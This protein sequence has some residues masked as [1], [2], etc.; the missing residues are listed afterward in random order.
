MKSYAEINDKIRSGKAVVLTAGEV[1]VLARSLS[2]GEIA[3]RV[4]VVTTAT[5]GATCSSGAFLNFGQATPPIRAER[6]ELNGVRACGGLGGGDTYVGATDGNPENP[7]RGGA[8][9]IEELVAGNEI[10]LEAWGR[11]TDCHPRK[12]V[13]TRVSMESLNEAYLYNPRNASR[14][15]NV[16]TNSTDRVMYTCMGTLLPKM[17][18]AAYATAGELSPLVNDPDCRVIGPGTRVFLCGTEG[19]VAWNGTRFTDNARSIAVTGDLKKMTTD[20]LR[21]VYYE[22][23]GT[24][25]FVGIG[26]PIPILDEDMA[27]RVSIRDEQIE[28]TIVDHGNEN[29][30]LGKTNHAALRSGEIV[31]NGQKVRTAPVSSLAKAREIAAILKSWIE[32][33]S[34]LLSEP[35]CPTRPLTRLNGLEE[36]EC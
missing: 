21:G 10:T 22:G 11:G 33:G 32:G 29:R 30:V 4:D 23:Y 9:V 12:H 3:R 5:F 15:C 25:L 34:F 28:V 31:I 16:A 6:I 24:A 8:H 14:D 18:N 20:F 7:A 17:R 1:S 36:R 35:A 26:I 13:K 2:P 27:R 19:Y